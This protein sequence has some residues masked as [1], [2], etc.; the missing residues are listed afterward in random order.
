MD[1]KTVQLLCEEGLGKNQSDITVTE[2]T[3]KSLDSTS[4]HHRIYR[5]L[6]ESYFLPYGDYPNI[7]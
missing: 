7:K 4:S 2:V 5:E 6:I 1:K 3:K